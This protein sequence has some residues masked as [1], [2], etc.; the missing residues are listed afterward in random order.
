MTIII[1]E[2][3]LIFFFPFGFLLIVEHDIPF[4]NKKIEMKPRTQA[5]TQKNRDATEQCIID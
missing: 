3:N 2:V 5:K 4:K 1:P